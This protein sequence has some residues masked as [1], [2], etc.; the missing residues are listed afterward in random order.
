[1]LGFRPRTLQRFAVQ[2]IV[3]VRASSNKVAMANDVHLSNKRIRTRIKM[4]KAR[5]AIFHQFDTLVELSDGSVIRRRSQAPRDE[6]RMVTD[7]RNH[8]LWNPH[9]DVE[10]ADIDARGKVSKFKEKFAQFQEE[11]EKTKGSTG[12]LLEMMGQNVTEVQKGG[13]VFTKKKK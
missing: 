2:Q 8:P 10:A 3:C 9:S 7:Q 11:G 5:P 4:G 1:M 12:S 6:I 13:R